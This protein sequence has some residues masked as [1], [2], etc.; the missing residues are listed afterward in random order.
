ML[1]AK[2]LPSNATSLINRKYIQSKKMFQ[3]LNS[4]ITFRSLFIRGS[5]K[6]SVI[7]DDLMTAS[8]SPHLKL[9]KAPK[10]IY[11]RRFENS[12][13]QDEKFWPNKKSRNQY[14]LAA[15]RPLNGA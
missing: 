8:P 6:S 9:D 14:E 2:R 15:A 5:A 11:P 7:S 10:T 13:V 12:K 1:I 3:K 4:L